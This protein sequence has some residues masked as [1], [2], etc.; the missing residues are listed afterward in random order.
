ML[1]PLGIVW[2]TWCF[3]VQGRI[4][5]FL[6]RGILLFGFCFRLP[7]QNQTNAFK[8]LLKCNSVMTTLGGFGMVMHMTMLKNMTQLCIFRAF[9]LHL[10]SLIVYIV[11]LLQCYLS[12]ESCMGNFVKSYV[13]PCGTWS[14]DICC[15]I[16]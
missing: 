11:R 14:F 16:V 2:G 9:L 3:R 5:L 4:P 10:C 12:T 7:T 1:L 8:W 13:L 15:L 6:H